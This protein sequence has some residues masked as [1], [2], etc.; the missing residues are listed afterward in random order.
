[1]RD[2]IGFADAG[3]RHGQ[4]AHRGD[5]RERP[6]LIAPVHEVLPARG[7]RRELRGPLDQQDELRWIAEG[8]RPQQH[9][10][11]DGEDRGV[12]ADAERERED[13]DGREAR[14]REQRPHGIANVAHEAIMQCGILN[15]ACGIRNFL[16]SYSA[17]RISHSASLYSCRSTTIGSTVLARRAGSQAATAATAS[18]TNA[19]VERMRGSAGATPASRP[20]TS[21]VKAIADASPIAAPMSARRSPSPTTSMI[22]RRASAPSATRTPISRIRVDT[23]YDSTP[24]TP[25]A[26]SSSAA[27]ANAPASVALKRGRASA[28]PTRSSS[29]IT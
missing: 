7:L 5:R 3:Q 27:A 2:A 19:P 24:Y 21:R 12:G 1:C 11:H 17:F 16:P 25:I 18:I 6:G 22:T 9:R 10:V 4:A 29:A 15:A 8:Q 26:A 28:A 13:G 20:C 23:E 14:P